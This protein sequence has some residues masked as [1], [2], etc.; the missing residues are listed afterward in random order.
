MDG[1]IC[2]TCKEKIGA[3]QKYRKLVFGRGIVE[4]PFC[5]SQLVVKKYGTS[6][7]MAELAAMITFWFLGIEKLAWLVVVLV[8]FAITLIQNILSPMVL[9]TPK[10]SI[11]RWATYLIKIWMLLLFVVLVI[12]SVRN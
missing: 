2:P 11:P 5:K 6:S 3:F 12:T 4:C 7:G 1:L 10:K 9:Y 8:W